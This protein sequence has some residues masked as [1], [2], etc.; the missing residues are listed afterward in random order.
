MLARGL[1][2]GVGERLPFVRHDGAVEHP[3]DVQPAA[4]RNEHRRPRDVGV[5]EELA[6]RRDRIV[7]RGVTVAALDVDVEEERLE[8]DRVLLRA[9]RQVVR[10]ALG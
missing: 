10:L 1:G 2:Q 6:E 5:L 4:G 3:V 8:P 9:D 7:T